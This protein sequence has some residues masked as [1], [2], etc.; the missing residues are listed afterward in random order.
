MADL[1]RKNLM[2]ERFKAR[3]KSGIGR[4]SGYCDLRTVAPINREW[5]NLRIVQRRINKLV[6]FLPY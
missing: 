5:K 4:G 2:I 6:E 1:P 3:L